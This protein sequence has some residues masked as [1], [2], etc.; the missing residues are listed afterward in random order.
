MNRVILPGKIIQ[1]E[2]PAKSEPIQIKSPTKREC[3]P[4]SS[5]SIIS[6]PPNMFFATLAKRMVYFSTSPRN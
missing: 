1:I 6:T 5:D 3:K 2:R 4:A